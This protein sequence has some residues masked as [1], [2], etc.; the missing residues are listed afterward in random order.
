LGQGVTTDWSQI[1]SFTAALAK[2]DAVVLID[3]ENSAGG[4]SV[5][6]LFKWIDTDSTFTYQLQ[7]AADPSFVNLVVNETGL[8]SGRYSLQTPLSP[9][10]GYS[11]RVRAR[12]ASGD[13]PWSSGRSFQTMVATP[14]QV[15]LASPDEGATDVP[16]LATLGWNAVANAGVYHLQLASDSGFASILVEDSA[17]ADVSITLDS[18]LPYDTTIYWH[19]RAGRDDGLDKVAGIVFGPWSGTRSFETEVGAPDAVTLSWPENGAV[20]VPPFTIL[21]WW[22]VP[23]ASGYHLQ[24]ASDSTFTGLVIEDSMIAET[25]ITLAQPLAYNTTFFWRVQAGRADE[26]GKSASILYGPWSAS[27]SFTVAIGTHT[28]RE[29][30]SP[31][32]FALESNYPNPFASSTTIWYSLPESGE[33]QVIVHDALGRPVEVLVSGHESAG[34]HAVVWNAEQIP[35]GEYFVTLQSGSRSETRHLL[36]TH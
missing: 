1:W 22:P 14:G 18:P 12:N 9:E 4:V 23:D 31:S 26:Q 3:P 6:P 32:E 10:T 24:I 17:I 21:S 20:G 5:N 35:S 30:V 25:S 34:R 29:A 27:R 13:G 2:P 28:E 19:V 15:I 36:I 33:V 7:V 11:W 8:T 16:T